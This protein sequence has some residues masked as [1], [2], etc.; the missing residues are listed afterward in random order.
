MSRLIDADDLFPSGIFMVDGRD[1]L[2][3]VGELIN[4]INNAPTI[5]AEP[6]CSPD[7]RWHGTRHQKCS[8]CRR[9]RYMKDNYEKVSCTKGTEA[10]K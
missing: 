10:V 7:C 4:M 6:P 2:K 3:S 5:E 8:R 9:N 1:P